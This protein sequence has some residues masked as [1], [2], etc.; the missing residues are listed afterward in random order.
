MNYNKI[1][2]Y[3]LLFI[4][5]CSLRAQDFSP[6]PYGIN[7]FDIAGPFTI[8]DL[9]VRQTGDLDGDRFIALKDILLYTSYLD[10][11]INLSDQD[12]DYA[13]INDD[14]AIDIL[15]IILGIDKIF[16]FTPAE[17]SFEDSWTGQESYM[18]IPS[19]S[20]WQQN[21]KLE[22]LQNSPLNVHYIFLS[23]LDSN[24][25]E[26]INLKNEFDIILDNFEPN[27]KAHWLAH[28]HYSSKNTLKDSVSIV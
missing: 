11:E 16:N 28:L 15:D 24:Y 22:L 27:L 18:L 3:I 26:M 21:L 4:L 6:G 9:S 10:G 8:E 2:H 7:Y 12:L 20:L 14:M 25:D 23:N 1:P 19:S 5:L 17:W 13:D